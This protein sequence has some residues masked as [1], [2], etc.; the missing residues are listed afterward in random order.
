M[1]D[2]ALGCDVV[3]G[4]GEVFPP[5]DVGGVEVALPGPR[6]TRPP[7]SRVSGKLNDGTLNEGTLNDGTLNEGT[8][9][10]GTLNEGTLNRRLGPDWFGD[11]VLTGVG[12]GL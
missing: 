7:R 3:G 2:V 4:A 10:D 5:L 11:S 6:G 12:G 9:N 1:G 8:P